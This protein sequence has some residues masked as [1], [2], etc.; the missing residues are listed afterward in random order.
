MASNQR[1]SAEQNPTARMLGLAAGFGI[2]QA[3]HVA[4]KLG[5]ADALAEG[6]TTV[7]AIAAKTDAQPRALYRLLRTLASVGVFAEEQHG[8][9]RNTPLS[10]MLMSDAAGSL[11]AFFNL[12]GSPECWRSWGELLYSVKTGKPA[13]EHVYGM[14]LFEYLANNPEPARI[15]DEAMASRSAAEIAAVLAA[16]DFS[17]CGHLV[18]VG[19]GN[20]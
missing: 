4:A 7:D 1:T 11:R 9:F 20:G 16:Y 19:G 2:F 5:I 3:L 18:D 15:F 13:F 12:A 6:P 14:P 8:V 10:G 17:G